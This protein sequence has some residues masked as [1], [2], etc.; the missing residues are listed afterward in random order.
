MSRPSTASRS[1][2][3]DPPSGAEQPGPRLAEWD[4]VLS[5][6][7]KLTPHK[8]TRVFEGWPGVS[9]QTPEGLNVSARTAKEL[10]R[11]TNQKDAQMLEWIGSFGAGD[12]FYDIGANVGGVTLTVAGIHANRIPIVAIEP[13][14]GSFESLARNLSL[15]GLLGTTIPLQIALL[16]QTGLQSLNYRSTAAGTSLH[17]VG[18]AVDHLGQDFIPV[19]VQLIPTYRLDDLIELMSLPQPTV[20]KIDVDGYEEPVL[21]GA[22]RVLTAGTIRE[23]N[24]EIVDHDRAATRLQAV[25]VLLEGCGYE[26]VRTFPHARVDSRVADYLFRRSESSA[27]LRLASRSAAEATPRSDQPLIDHEADGADPQ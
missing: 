8:Q 27:D 7:L 13:S 6:L 21:R 3:P 20:V 17:A 15:N 16:D 9:G 18:A 4:E 1:L 14:F 2:D 22:V 24:V 5:A 26:L 12:V 11:F 19:E 23:L 10:R 25:T